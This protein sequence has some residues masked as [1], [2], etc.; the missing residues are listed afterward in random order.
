MSSRLSLPIVPGRGCSA[1]PKNRFEKI[2]VQPELESLDPDDALQLAAGKRPTEYFEDDSQS[3][4]SEN[5]SPDLPFRYS[6][7][8]YRGCAHGCSYC[9]ARPTHQYLGFSAGLDFESKI[10]VKRMAADLLRQFLARPQWHPQPIMLSGVTDPYQ[11]GERQFQVTRQ[12][13]QVALEF[14]QP[15]MLI[16]KNSLLTRDLDFIAELARR[17]LVSVAISITTL[18]QSLTKSLEPRTSTPQARLRAIRELSSAGVPVCVMAAPLI[19]G[20]TDWEM[21]S[22][23]ESAA[24]AGAR[25]AGYTMLRLPQEVAGIFEEWLSQRVPD[26]S[27]KILGRVRQVRGGELSQSGF[28]ERMKGTG[29]LA[30]QTAQAFKVFQRRY[31]LDA[32]APTLDCSQFRVPDRSGQRRL[33]D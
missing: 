30:R 3:V 19:P 27:E 18:D 15:V 7:N 10:I 8:P 11:P 20:L 9:Y 17:Q 5:H 26:Q 32:K 14:G 31:A 12:C 33:F 23:L 4:V 28:G 13:L 16:T 24:E 29:T 6:L 22:I 1:N 25:S 21:P 2:E